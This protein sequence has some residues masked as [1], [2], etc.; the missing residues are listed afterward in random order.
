MSAIGRILIIKLSSLG[1]VVHTLPAVAA[2]KKAYPQAQIDWLVEKKCSILLKNNPLIHEVIEV[3][4]HQWRKSL[5]SLEAFGQF[6]SILGRL[7][8]NQYDVALDFQG[9]WKS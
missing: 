4:T 5:L 7:R 1:D 9:L 8:A 3:D 6:K 2:L